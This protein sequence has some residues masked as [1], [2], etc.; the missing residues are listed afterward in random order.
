MRIALDEI[1]Q[2]ISDGNYYIAFTHTEKLRKRKIDIAQ[3]EKAISTGEI[4]ESYP[5][6]PR[7]PSCLIMGHF[8]GERPLHVVCGKVQE[9]IIIITAYEPD[10]VEW[11]ADFR[12]RR[13]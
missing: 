11:E 9:Q 5:D 10:S 13:K 8:E 1:K 7:G 12:T 6:D 4:I 3:V 2:K